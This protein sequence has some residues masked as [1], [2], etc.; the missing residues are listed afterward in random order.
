M[1]AHLNISIPPLKPDERV[2]DWQPLFVVA[3]SPLAAHAGEKAA[4]LILPSY[5]CR[6]EYEREMALIAMNSFKSGK[7][8]PITSTILIHS[9]H[10]KFKLKSDNFECYTT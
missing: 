4:V 8:L 6:N 9:Y 5:V 2:E 1:A 7:I 3:T 10:R